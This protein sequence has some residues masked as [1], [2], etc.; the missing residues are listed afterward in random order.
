MYHVMLRC[1]TVEAVHY[2]YH[3]QQCHSPLQAPL[4]VLEAT[5]FR[6]VLTT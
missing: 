2:A 3:A 5:T 6:A 1:V 4:Q